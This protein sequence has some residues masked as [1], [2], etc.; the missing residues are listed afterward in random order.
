[1]HFP[2]FFA[3]LV[4]YA[5]AAKDDASG[6]EA[7]EDYIELTDLQYN[8][9][10]AGQILPRDRSVLQEREVSIYLRQGFVYECYR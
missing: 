2:K 3:T 4:G 5:V 9:S 7:D 8:M 10:Q 1:M 6:E